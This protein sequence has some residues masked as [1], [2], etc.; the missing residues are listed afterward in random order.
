MLGE[1]LHAVGRRIEGRDAEAGAFGPI[2]AVV[3]VGAHPRDTPKPEHVLHT[4]RE[5]ALARC[6]VAGESQQQRACSAGARQASPD[7]QRGGGAVH[8]LRRYRTH[9]YPSDTGNRGR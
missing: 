2:E 6:A 3:I 9:E 4:P 7:R 1:Q 8:G 5:G